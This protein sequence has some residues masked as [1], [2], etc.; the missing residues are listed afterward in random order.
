MAF[1]AILAVGALLVS[2]VSLVLRPKAKR[3]QPEETKELESPTAGEGRFIMV[4]WGD[5][6]VESGNVLW[7]GDK[8]TYTYKEKLK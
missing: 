2:V 4:I 8:S 6:T 7:W 3:N 5:V 1:W